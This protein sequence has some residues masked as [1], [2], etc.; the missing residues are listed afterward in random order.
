MYSGAFCFEEE[1][2]LAPAAAHR[3]PAAAPADD[4]LPAATVAPPPERG[5]PPALP[6]P[7]PLVYVRS[8][9]LAQLSAGLPINR[10]RSVMT[11]TL[12]EDYG[13]LQASE[14]G[15]AGGGPCW[16]WTES[17]FG[18][19]HPAIP[20]L[21]LPPHHDAAPGRGGAS[22][23]TCQPGAAAGLPQQVG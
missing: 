5:P 1:E 16:R 7:R 17:S 3:A 19:R 14:K 21:R 22:G 2:G 6:A 13:L 8:D 12:V 23:A 18:F 4:Q 20:P 11:D 15:P 9:R 10:D